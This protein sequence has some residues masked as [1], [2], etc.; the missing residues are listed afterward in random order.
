ME[1][2]ILNPNPYGP[3]SEERL[4][5]FERRIGTTLPPDYRAF[6]LRYNGGQ[7]QPGGFWIKEGVEGSDVCRFYGLHDGPTWYMI[8]AY[9]ERPQLGI[10]PGLLVI[11]DDGTGNRICLSVREDERGAVYF[12]DH[13]LHPRNPETYEGITKLADSFTEFLAGLTQPIE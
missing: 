8:E 1:V 4:E 7:P 2:T 3:L 11:G 10:P 12:Y 5:A 6:L 9:L 13:E